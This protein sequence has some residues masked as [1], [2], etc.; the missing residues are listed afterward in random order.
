M[1]DIWAGES[2][3]LG[4]TDLG[5]ALSP[6]LGMHPGLPEGHEGCWPD[7]L[8]TGIAGNGGTE[9]VVSANLVSYMHFHSLKT[10]QTQVTEADKSF[11]HSFMHALI[12]SFNGYLLSAYSVPAFIQ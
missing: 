7:E 2:G 12:H 11:T 3:L 5:E 1:A 10:R 8:T 4:P 9:W 6:P